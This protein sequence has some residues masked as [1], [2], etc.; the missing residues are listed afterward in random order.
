ML[1]PLMMLLF[2]NSFF[3]LTT[4][5]AQT[6]TVTTDKLDYSPGS[7]VRISGRGWTSFETV[8][9]QVLHDGVTGDNASSAH[10]RHGL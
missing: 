9:L 4:V 8:T 3:F 6:A 7:T 1:F 5:S 10:M 2:T